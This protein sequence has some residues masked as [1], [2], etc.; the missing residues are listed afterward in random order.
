M[1]RIYVLY[2]LLQFSVLLLYAQEEEIETISVNTD[3]S[4]HFIL[5]EPIEYVDISTNAVVGDLPASNILRIKP[6][7][8]SLDLGVVTIVGEQYMVQYKLEWGSVKEAVKRKKVTRSDGIGIKNLNVKLS[9]EHMEYFSLE[10]IKR[11]PSY[12]TVKSQG[13]KMEVK[14]NNIYT[15]KDYFFIDISCLNHTN[16]KYDIDQIR[17][18]IE[19]K[20]MVKATNFQQV[21]IEP[22]YQ[23]YEDVNA[24]KKKYR[25]VFAFPKFT[26]PDEKVFTIEFAEKQ[27]SGRTITLKI[28]YSDVLNADIL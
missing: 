20:K 22:E 1:K 14:L 6:L 24:F 19:D 2:T 13:T 5:S 23:L 26:F 3:I 17:F 11:K 16:I 25:N 7:E 21:E 27:I 9:K 15:I 28:D 4:T 8:D 10:I 18:K 12:F